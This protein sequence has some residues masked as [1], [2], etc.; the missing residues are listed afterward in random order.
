MQR[1]H[2]KGGV[3]EAIYKKVRNAIVKY[4]AKSCPFMFIKF[5]QTFV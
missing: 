2:G 3:C 5:S 4:M 1:L